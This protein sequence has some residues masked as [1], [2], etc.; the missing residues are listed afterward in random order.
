LEEALAAFDAAIALNADFVEAHENRFVILTELGRSKEAAE[1]IERAI[2]I[3]PNRARAYYNLTET[4]RIE[5]GSPYLKGME[6]LSRDLNSLPQGEQIYLCFALGKSYADIG[7]YDLSFS[8]ISKGT[9]LKRTEMSYNESGTLMMLKRAAK[10][11]NPTVMKRDRAAGAPSPA[12]VFILGMPRSGT[13]L[14][15]QLLASHPDVYAAGEIEAFLTTMVQCAADERFDDTPEAFA[16]LSDPALRR[17]GLAYLDRMRR[18]APTAERIVDKSLQSFRFA[19]L[20]NLALPNAKFIHA[21][22]NPAD[23]C[24]SCFTKLFTDDLPYTYDLTELGRYYRGHE[25]LMAHWRSV[26]PEGVMLEVRYE[27]VVADFETQ[28]RRILDHCGLDWNPAC[29]DFHLTQRPVRTASVTQVRQPI[30]ASSVGRWRA[31]ERHLGPL[32]EALAGG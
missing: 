14:V 9:A 23:T 3:A 1:S 28:A 11:F 8:W 7:D 19:G 26:L 22:R 29:L 5:A 27:D 31:Y 13:T 15:E 6:V 17:L 2:R 21:R 32:N 4:R 25:E 18:L 20:I 12:P 24:L 16:R 30:Y 10:A